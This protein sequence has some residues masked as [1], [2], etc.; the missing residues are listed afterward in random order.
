[1][2]I[3]S[4]RVVLTAC[5][6]ALVAAGTVN[7]TPSSPSV[8]AT[9]SRSGNR[10]DGDAFHHRD[11]RDDDWRR[12]SKDGQ[13]RKVAKPTVGRAATVSRR[14]PSESSSSSERRASTSAKGTKPPPGSPCATSGTTARCGKT[15]ST[16]TGGRDQAYSV[17]VEPYTCGDSNA[18][19]G[20]W[21]RWKKTKPTDDEGTAASD[22]GSSAQPTNV[23]MPLPVY[24]ANGRSSPGSS[25]RVFEI[26]VGQLD[27]LYTVRR[28]RTT[29]VG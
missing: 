25:R 29:T 10:V 21:R 17:K 2:T 18:R 9:A 7:L 6:W 19:K 28:E 13:T 23:M 1:M 11:R 27:L 22:V 20:K 3:F 12:R 4:V 8:Y 24:P 5:T 14:L 15:P 26:P 16:G